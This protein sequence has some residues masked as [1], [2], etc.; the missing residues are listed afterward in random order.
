MLEPA[1]DATHGEGSEL[2]PFENNYM[3]RLFASHPTIFIL[4]GI[5]FIGDVVMIAVTGS[6]WG[7]SY[8]LGS[9]LAVVYFLGISLLLRFVVFR[10]RIHSG[11]TWGITILM[12]FGW[13]VLQAA[14]NQ[15]Q[16]RPSLLFIMCIL[17]AFKTMRLKESEEE[18]IASASKASDKNSDINNNRDKQN[19][20]SYD[21]ALNNDKINTSDP[22]EKPPE[23]PSP[24]PI[25]VTQPIGTNTVDSQK[26]LRSLKQVLGIMALIGCL[27]A[28]FDMPVNYY[29]LLRF[30][31]VA[32]CG[33]IIWDLHKS[34]SSD[35]KKTWFTVIFGMLAIFYNPIMPIELDEDSWRWFNL[36]GAVVFALLVIGKATAISL[37]II[38]TTLLL[39]IDYAKYEKQIAYEK[40]YDEKMKQIREEENKK[41][42]EEQ[43]RMDKLWAER[44]AERKKEQQ[45]AQERLEKSKLE[46]Q[47]KEEKANKILQAAQ[48][49]REL[50]I[51]RNL[52]KNLNRKKS[53]DKQIADYDT[54]IHQFLKKRIDLNREKEF[55]VIGE[56]TNSGYY[57]FTSDETMALIF[58]SLI[59]E[60][61]TILNAINRA[62]G[63]TIKANTKNLTVKR[64]A[65]SE[66]QTLKVDTG[67]LNDSNDF[68]V[69]PSDIIEI[70]QQ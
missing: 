12:Y 55:M 11:L 66:T 3:K 43:E 46:N 9:I 42:R 27:I 26:N 20:N 40:A 7:G 19:E 22:F 45:K 51:E 2:F 47:I 8:A 28:L 13:F 58:P 14:L 44:E 29:K 17:A 37:A 65:G 1:L 34:S 5:A 38:S 56:V 64:I 25:P 30:I 31:V 4:L 23:P 69:L 49:R 68:K 59:E 62:G 21:Y 48:K 35:A 10:K 33:I 18:R 32:A 41:K 24:I 6:L 63:F 61:L 52:E 39:A 67:K 54:Q 36:V 16:Y 60:P 15:G 70:S 53:L 57:K 50:E